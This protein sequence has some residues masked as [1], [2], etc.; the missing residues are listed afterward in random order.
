MTEAETEGETREGSGQPR[1]AIEERFARLA[2]GGLPSL[3]C[4]PDLN[5][6]DL[7][8]NYLFKH[9]SFY[10]PQVDHARLGLGRRTFSIVNSEAASEL[11]TVLFLLSLLLAQATGNQKSKAGGFVASQGEDNLFEMAVEEDFNELVLLIAFLA[12]R[13][14]RLEV[15][16]A[17]Y[18]IGLDRLHLEPECWK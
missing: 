4:V 13:A 18:M 17:D 1:K 3:L 2:S 15:R 10:N 7:L 12:K 16:L 11:T 8:R 9:L 6:R 14:W 5:Q